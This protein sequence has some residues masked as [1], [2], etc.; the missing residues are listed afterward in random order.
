MSIYNRK[1]HMQ[2]HRLNGGAVGIMNTRRKRL[3]KQ[4]RAHRNEFKRQLRDAKKS[5]PQELR[6][7]VNWNDVRA[8][9]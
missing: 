6:A 2:G 9:Q 1:G 4:Q 5:V 7:K 8:K 3:L